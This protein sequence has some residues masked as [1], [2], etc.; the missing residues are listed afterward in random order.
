MNDRVYFHLLTIHFMALEKTPTFSGSLIFSRLSQKKIS[1]SSRLDSN[2][3]AKTRKGY[4]GMI[5]RL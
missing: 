4:A 1:L 5:I 3:I 2:S